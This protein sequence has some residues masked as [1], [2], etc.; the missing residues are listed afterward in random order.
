MIPKCSY[1]M[2][3]TSVLRVIKVLRSHLV[4]HHDLCGTFDFRLACMSSIIISL[5]SKR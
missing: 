4:H 3:R 2:V 5:K 1:F